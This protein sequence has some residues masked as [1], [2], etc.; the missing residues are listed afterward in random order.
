MLNR[1]V[2]VTALCLAALTAAGCSCQE[3]PP[4]RPATPTWTPTRATTPTRT[5]CDDGRDECKGECC[6]DDS[7][8]STNERLL[9]PQGL[10]LRFGTCCGSRRSRAKGPSCHKDCA[11]DARCRDENG[12]EMCCGANEMCISSQCFEPVTPCTDFLDCGVDEYCEASMGYCL[13]QPG[14]DA[15]E[16]KPS[17]G[18]VVP[19]LVWEWNGWGRAEPAYNQVMMTPI[20]IN[21]NDDNSDG[22]VDE[23]DTPDV[24]FSTF[25]ANNPAC[26][27]YECDGILRAVN[28]DDGSTLFDQTGG[29][30]RVMPGG[31]LAAGDIDGDGLPEIVACSSDADR[32][33]RLIAFENDGSFKWISPDDGA[34]QCGQA[35]PSIADLDADG[36]PEVFV[37][38]TV[39]NGK[40]GA[41]KW[42]KPCKN[43]GAFPEAG[44]DGGHTAC[45]YT[46]AA[47][48]DGD[49]KLEVV[50][51]NQAFHANGS[52]Y[53]DRSAS[54][55]DGYPAIAD[56]DL[57][58]QPEVVV[59]Q[60]AWDAVH[61]GD[62]Y[63]RALRRDGRDYWGPIDINQGMA[64]AGDKA[65]GTLAGG[66]PATIAN[67]DTDAEPEIALAG[68]FGYVVF[69]ADGTR[70]WF[71]TTRDD[72]SRNTG[73]SVFDFDGDG[74]AEAVYN[75]E[76]WLRVYNGAT[77]K[78]RYCQCNTSATLWE[79]PVIADVD[80]DGHAE[81]V[82]SSND[83]SS[84][85][86]NC[87]KAD[88]LDECT[89]DLVKNG[90]LPATHGVRVYASPK[91]D[92]VG[93]RRIWNQYQYHITNVKED[94]TIPQ[95]ERRNWTSPYLNNFRQ[96]LQPDALNLT[97]GTP[98]EFAVDLSQC[99]LT[100]GVNFE[101]SNAGWAAL[102]AGT[103]VTLYVQADDAWVKVVTLTTP[104][105]VLPGDSL[106]MSHPFPT[107]QNDHRF[108]VVVNDP[109]RRRKCAGGRVPL[110]EQLGGSGRDLLAAVLKRRCSG[111]NAPI[112]AFLSTVA[113][114]GG[115]P[116]R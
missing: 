90:S 39:V 47:D 51:G 30:F 95:H 97:D 108:R 1:I 17:G 79:Y 60:S 29:F 8:C 71:A 56:L 37:R 106:I 82:V 23:N 77:G 31:Q 13:P 42:S 88:A 27:T 67:F 113:F 10:A 25:N 54:F 76:H 14:G 66:G 24:I 45:D 61:K 59:V 46:T 81:I 111:A 34:V 36:Q 84:V 41:T 49:G 75:D 2:S 85:I 98:I 87:S 32:F 80:N 5:I 93:T 102:V 48:L 92:W 68:A 104:R 57:D 101:V 50:G 63:I 65:D 4:P 35:A 26:K 55:R 38:Y 89:K 86:G 110:R 12:V 91:R 64:P 16:I 70:K 114:D 62:H 116:S 112:A 83:F 15:C 33:G 19:T 109:E 94:G 99:P 43:I 58:G 44:K 28:G 11:S 53:W 52:L 22:S 74:V 96:N 115:W 100:M 40:T 103:P 18:A 107:T 73:S 72:T 20:V 78:V 6:G 7:V 21:L 9:R 69:E 105:T 3:R